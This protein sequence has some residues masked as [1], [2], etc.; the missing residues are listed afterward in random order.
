MADNPQPT[1]TDYTNA[2]LDAGYRRTAAPML[3]QIIALSASASM[4]RAL[5]DLDAE[6]ERLDAEGKRMDADNPVLRVAMAEFTAV[7]QT[8][9]RLITA[10]DNDIQASGQVIAIP[11]VTG[12]VFTKLAQDIMRAGINPVSPAATKAYR[13]ALKAAGLK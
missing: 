11:S 12:K 1:M 7:M 6:A 5:S 13:D 9:S 4:Q 2:A 3:K 10:N 8:T